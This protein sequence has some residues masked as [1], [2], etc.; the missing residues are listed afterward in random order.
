M[1]SLFHW[2]LGGTWLS[3]VGPGSV[4]LWWWQAGWGPREGGMKQGPATGT[5]VS[6]LGS[7]GRDI[8]FGS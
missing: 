3:P 5:A 7:G 8:G 4:P 1:R 6:G 2:L